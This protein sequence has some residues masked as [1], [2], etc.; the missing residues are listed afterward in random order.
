[1]HPEM[2]HPEMKLGFYYSDVMCSR[3]RANRNLFPHATRDHCD[4][5][6]QQHESLELD[7][8]V[9]CGHMKSPS[10]CIMKLVGWKSS[11]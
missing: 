11:S 3:S 5:V 8:Y 7:T 4:C 9:A 10:K 1:M 6:L 2:K